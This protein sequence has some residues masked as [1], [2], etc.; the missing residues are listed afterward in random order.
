[1]I[2]FKRIGIELSGGII[3]T[4]FRAYFPD[5]PNYMIDI[6]VNCYS[7]TDASNAKLYIR[8]TTT[9]NIDNKSWRTI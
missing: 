9:G 1:M 5:L 6:V 8:G 3:C 2:G 4:G 7:G